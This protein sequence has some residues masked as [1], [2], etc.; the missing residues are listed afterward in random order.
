MIQVKRQMAG[1]AVASVVMLMAGSAAESATYKLTIA[2]GHVQAGLWVATIKNFF[3]PRVAERSAKETSHAIEWTEGWGGSLCKIGECLEAVESGLVDIADVH[4][5]T[6]PAKLMP[7]N[8]F[9]YAPF[10]APDPRVGAKVAAAMYDKVPELRTM[11]EQRYNQVFVGAGIVGNYG[12][13]TNFTWNSVADLKGRKIAAIGPNFPWLQGTGAIPVQSN[14]NEAYT[15]M[16]T[17][18]YEG[19]VMLADPTVSFKL[20][21]VSKQFVDMDFGSIHTPLLTMN[22]DSFRKLPSEVQKIILE[23]GK[24]FN[25]RMGE[26]TYE[27]QVAATNFLKQAGLV[28][29]QADMETKQ[30]WA[31]QLVNLPKQRAEEM[32]KQR[33]PGEVVYT[34]IKELKANGHT[35]PRDWEAER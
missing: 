23:V 29:K 13:V 26:V 5:P 27:K 34:Y 32:N 2:A 7:H 25:T 35:F 9:Y 1:A 19:W 12:L 14:L 22:R 28:V 10:G 21:E 8:V 3:M 15:A 17:G 30:T 18:V 33:M 20:H 4:V 24:E 31:K 16:Q 11:L 6:E